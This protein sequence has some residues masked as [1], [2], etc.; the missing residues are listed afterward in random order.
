MKP[1]LQSTS[2]VQR[3]YWLI[4]LRWVAI[5]MLC[6][7]AFTAGRIFNISVNDYKLYII[8]AILILYNFLLYDL[9][10]YFT[11]GGRRPS[12]ERVSRVIFFQISAD[13]FILT[14]ILHYSGGIENPF[15]FYFV[16]HMVIASIL[17][18]PLQSYL[19]ATLAIILFGTLLMLE[20]LGVLPHY[21][22]GG[23]V[24][25]DLYQDKLFIFVTFFVFLTTIYLVVYMT[26]SISA[27]LRKRQEDYEKVNLQLQQKDRLKNEYVMRLTHDVRGHL[28]AITSC[29]DIVTDGMLGQLNDKQADVVERASRRTDKCMAFVTALLRITRLKLSDSMEMSNISLK[30]IFFNAMSEVESSAAS[31]SIDLDYRTDSAVDEVY[32]DPVLLE[33]V[34]TNLLLNAV[35]Y[36]PENGKVELI[37]K[38][39]GNN[40]LIEVRDTG[41]GI[42]PDEIDRL[43]E[44]FYRATNAR[45]IE[46]E[47]TGLGLAIVKQVIERHGGKV[48]AQ[49]NPAGGSTFSLTLPK[50]SGHPAV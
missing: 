33:E 17:L 19:Q 29:L 6:I 12:H 10:N 27:L 20:Y 13:L 35:K 47:G 41:I 42:P 24:G 36:T 15:F 31:K 46:R 9:M 4:K 16:F 23:F 8:A 21:N 43:F 5:V 32:C 26:T 38:D 40:I 14:A 37:A 39:E 7:S 50:A 25:L 2:L 3:S 1:L 11:W 28:A 48:W 30:N 22:L 45:K 18:T 34:I 44:E 49:N